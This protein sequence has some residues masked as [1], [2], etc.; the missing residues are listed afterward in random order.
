[1]PQD[2]NKAQ[3]S[4][5][6]LRVRNMRSTL[7][8]LSALCYAVP[9]VL[10]HGQVRNFIAASGTYPSADAYASALPNSPI[11]KLNTYGPAADFTSVNITCGEGGNIPVTALATVNAGETVMTWMAKCPNGCAS[12][13]GDSGSIWVKIDQDVYHP[14]RTAMPWGE[15]ILHNGGK[16]S[17]V[18]PAGLQNGEYILR[19][20]LSGYVQILG[21][22]VAG[23]LMGA[24]FYPNCVQVKVQ[25]GGSKTL[26]AGQ[27]LPGAYKPT[28]PGI[29][30]QL[31][32]FTPSNATYVAPAGS[33]TF[34]GGTG[35][36]GASLGA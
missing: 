13:K 20:E 31:W 12:F 2:I 6:Y 33:V 9:F 34:P 26:P 25:N 23:E 7:L 8:S 11:R 17:V 10:A 35:D 28:D 24:Q 30:T 19:H 3:S 36:W 29:L 5:G 4:I 18:I 21:L 16:Y 15:N 22:H 1:M 14:A 27:A 32:W